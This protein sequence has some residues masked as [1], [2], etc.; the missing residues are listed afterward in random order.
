[1]LTA[2]VATPLPSLPVETP[3]VNA[4]AVLWFILLLAGVVAVLRG[5]LASQRRDRTARKS[6]RRTLI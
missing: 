5:L 4:A 2:S 6:N 1:M 3:Y